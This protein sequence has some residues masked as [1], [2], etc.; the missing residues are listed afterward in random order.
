MLT[1]M[2]SCFRSAILLGIVLYLSLVVVFHSQLRLVQNSTDNVTESRQA[3]NDDYVA[4]LTTPL[5][6]HCVDINKNNDTVSKFQPVGDHYVFSAF[7]DDRLASYGEVVI[8]IIAVVKETKPVHK[9]QASF[10]CHVISGGGDR[11]WTVSGE[12]YEM[13][14]NHGKTYGGWIV[15]CRLPVGGGGLPPCHVTVSHSDGGD[16]ATLPVMRM[17]PDVERRRPLGVCLPPLFGHVPSTTI[18]EF[19]EMSR[20]LGVDHVIVYRLPQLSREVCQQ[21]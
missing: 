14:E 1:S 7:L 20:L 3:G 11:K 10:R 18:V 4:T 9:P 12:M 17:S 2:T 21:P 16:M 13:C 6:R 15:T 8:R 5:F 19:V